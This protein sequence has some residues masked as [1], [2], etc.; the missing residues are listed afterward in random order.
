MRS[1]FILVVIVVG[2]LIRAGTFSC[3]GERIMEK[4]S[5]AR[6]RVNERKIHDPDR[7]QPPVVNPGPS[8]P[9]ENY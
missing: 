6:D 8:G 1:I 5:Q 3:Q 9:P 2:I 7:P 4:K